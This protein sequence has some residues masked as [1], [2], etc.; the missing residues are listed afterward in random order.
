[1]NIT[2]RDGKNIDIDMKYQLL[3]TIDML[4]NKINGAVA[5]PARQHIILVNEDA[6]GLNEIK[7]NI[8]HSFKAKIPFIKKW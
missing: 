8:F 3:K 4:Q 5:S 2:I 7:N 1:M 6:G